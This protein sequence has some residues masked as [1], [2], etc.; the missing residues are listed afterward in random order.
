MIVFVNE[1][2]LV[3]FS[4]AKLADALLMHGDSTLAGVKSGRLYVLD[5]YGNRM[6]TS[7]ALTEG[8]RYF[9]RTTENEKQQ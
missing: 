7:G 9:V 3:L 6:N 4:G 5:R 2:E 8:G 1:K